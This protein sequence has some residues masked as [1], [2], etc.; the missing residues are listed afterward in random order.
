MPAISASFYAD[1]LPA[2]DTILYTIPAAQIGHI[3]FGVSHAGYGGPKRFNIEIKRAATG[4][5]V[6]ISGKDARVFPGGTW[7]WPD[8]G[9]GLQLSEGDEIHG[10][11]DSQIDCLITGALE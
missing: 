11:G 6:S 7:S 9:I 8:T 10:W 5:Q 3:K 2:S 1:A 4:K